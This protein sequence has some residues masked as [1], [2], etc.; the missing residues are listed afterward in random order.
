M[1]A[2]ITIVETDF[3]HAPLAKQGDTDMRK[4]ANGQAME[5]VDISCHKN[6]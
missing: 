4:P 5:I 2:G 1:I 6:E 3:S